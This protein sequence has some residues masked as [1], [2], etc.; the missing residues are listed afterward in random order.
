MVE[1]PE[2]TVDHAGLEVLDR[3]ECL[4]LLEAGGV[5]RVALAGD[6]PVIR[7][8]N[9]VLDGD[10]IVVRTGPGALAQ[11]AAEQRLATFEIDHARNVD[12]HGWSV[13]ASGPLSLVAADEDTLTLPLRAWAR[14]GRDRFVAIHI[15]QLSGRRL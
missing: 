11:S 9:F 13:I 2:R 7:P 1:Q 15:A 8:V 12:H 3:V 10:R 6:P 5:G 4:R 14:R